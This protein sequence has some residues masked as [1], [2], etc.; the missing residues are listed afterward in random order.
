ML[1]LPPR[2]TRTDT[3]FPYPTLCRSVISRLLAGLGEYTSTLQTN[4]HDPRT[5]S[6]TERG[7][8]YVDY[9]SLIGGEGLPASGRFVNAAIRQAELAGY[10]RPVEIRRHQLRHI[11]GQFRSVAFSLHRRFQPTFRSSTGSASCRQRGCTYV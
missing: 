2:S 10:V 5:L 7:V 4:P 8:F 3:L 6:T 1:R 11:V 9:A